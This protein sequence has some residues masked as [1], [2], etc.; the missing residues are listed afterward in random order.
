MKWKAAAIVALIA[1]SLGVLH[2]FSVTLP[3][4]RPPLPHPA[5]Y[6]AS[7]AGAKTCD[8]VRWDWSVLERGSNSNSPGLDDNLMGG[9][10]RYR[11]PY[12]IEPRTLLWTDQ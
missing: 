10:L 4:L 6:I 11:P 5:G 7:G 9:S 8:Q 1:V 12:H 3:H 2:F